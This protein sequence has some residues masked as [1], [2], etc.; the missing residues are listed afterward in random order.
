MRRRE[1]LGLA[2]LLRLS[3]PMKSGTKLR[4][5]GDEARAAVRV[6]VL[7]E[8]TI[9]SQARAYAEY[10]VFAALTQ[11][12]E[13]QKVRRARVVLRPVNGRGSCDRVACTVTIA[14]DGADSLRVRTIG[15]HAYAAINRAVERITTVKEPE[16][17]DRISP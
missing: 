12:T 4:T 3:H 1:I 14:L 6:E 13:A 10:R 9:G 7:G 8:D 5:S 17:L 11:I 2:C 15:A 16:V